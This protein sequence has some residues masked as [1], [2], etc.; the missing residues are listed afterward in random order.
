MLKLVFI[1]LTIPHAEVKNQTKG[2]SCF[3]E[4]KIPKLFLFTAD[5]IFCPA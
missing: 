2:N 1:L 3:V 5:R 4:T